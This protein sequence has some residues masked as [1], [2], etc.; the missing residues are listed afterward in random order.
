MSEITERVNDNLQKA[1]EHIHAS[2]QRFYTLG[3]IPQLADKLQHHA[4]S[5]ETCKK[6]L[7]N[8][9][10]LSERADYYINE[11]VQSRKK[12]E[13][14]IRMAKRHL[15][16]EHAISER[17]FYTSLYT[18]WGLLAGTGIG[19]GLSILLNFPVFEVILLCITIFLVVFRFIGSAKDKA[20]KKRGNQL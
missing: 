16:Q 5:C 20:Q 7:K 2:D 15:K 12:Y 6:E 19:I 10:L 8:I 4:Q 18:I 3:I 11:S 1:A 17:S 14:V 9:V 13:E